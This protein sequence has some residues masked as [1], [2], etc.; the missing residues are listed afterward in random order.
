MS[1]HNISLLV[2]IVTLV[3]IGVSDTEH[4]EEKAI[5]WHAYDGGV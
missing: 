2:Q 3:C 4:N 1:T 5:K